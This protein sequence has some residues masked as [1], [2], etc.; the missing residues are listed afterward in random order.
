[1]AAS[2]SI[3]LALAALSFWVGIGA[4][5]LNRFWSWLALG[6]TA[7][8]GGPMFLRLYWWRCNA[9]DAAGSLATAPVDEAVTANFVCVTRPFG[10]WGKYARLLSEEDRRE[11]RRDIGAVPFV[12][13]AQVTLFLFAMQVVLRDAPGAAVSG[14]LC[15]CSCFAVWR[16]WGRYL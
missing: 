6:L 4:P 7:G 12:M 5:D 14:A 3:S 11:H 13:L 15:L 2:Y 1:M 16:V 9:A 8:N 10:A